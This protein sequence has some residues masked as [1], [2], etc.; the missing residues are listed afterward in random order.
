MVSWVGGVALRI[1]S[2]LSVDALRLFGGGVWRGCFFCD[3]FGLEDDWSSSS[4]ACGA[5]G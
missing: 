3:C 4:F 1:D 2:G 5:D